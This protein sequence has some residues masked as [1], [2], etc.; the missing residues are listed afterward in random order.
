MMRQKSSTS[1]DTQAF[2]QGRDC[3][4]R[5][6]PEWRCQRILHQKPQPDLSWIDELEFLD[7]IY[8]DG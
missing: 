5:L 2:S 8:D 4:G 7:T 3:K 1:A 6:R